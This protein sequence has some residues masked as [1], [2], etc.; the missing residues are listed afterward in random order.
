[1]EMAQ[2]ES[3]SQRIPAGERAAVFTSAVAPPSYDS[4]PADQQKQQPS[5]APQQQVPVQQLQQGV[6]FQAWPQGQVYH[7]PAPVVGGVHQQGPVQYIAVS[8]TV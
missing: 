1:M 4:L 7:Q 2:T 3:T 6:P 5:A 8:E